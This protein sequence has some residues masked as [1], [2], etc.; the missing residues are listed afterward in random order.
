MNDARRESN[1]SENMA[2]GGGH[3]FRRHP[4][5]LLGIY[6]ALALGV[7]CAIS[8]LIL[9]P[10]PIDR[11]TWRNAPAMDLPYRLT[12]P[13]KAEAGEHFMILVSGHDQAEY[14]LAGL[15][16][17]LTPLE[18]NPEIYWGLNDDD[19]R[20]LL[21]AGEPAIAFD[22][23][24]LVENPTISSLQAYKT[25]ATY[26]SY[27]SNLIAVDNIELSRRGLAG[28]RIGLLEDQSSR[29]GHLVPISVFRS[30]GLAP[31]DYMA[32]LANNHQ[33][34]RTLL[35]AGE[36]DVIASYW[37]EKDKRNYVDWLSVEIG[38]NITG[39]AWYLKPDLYGSPFS[40]IFQRILIAS[41]EKTAN[42]YFQQVEIVANDC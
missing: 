41:A 15:C 39:A 24:H 40:C 27:T 13:A 20:T 5:S 37:G 34:L 38:A 10:A 30:L 6:A 29:S 23:A 26:P 7:S 22:R 1:L 19:R 16:P 21:K 28:K 2:W 33:E 9:N 17:A 42:N 3:R 25:L 18:I 11:A 36:V 35:A 4:R 14:L 31:A 12:C 8:Y 32:V